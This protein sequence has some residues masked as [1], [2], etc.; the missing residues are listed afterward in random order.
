MISPGVSLKE[1]GGVDNNSLALQAG[2]IALAKQC[3]KDR[4]GAQLLQ[5]DHGIFK[6]YSWIMDGQ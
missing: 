3:R 4:T 5:L 1:E 2:D 6:I